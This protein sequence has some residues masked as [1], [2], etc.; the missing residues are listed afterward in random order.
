MSD[1]QPQGGENPHP[2]VELAVEMAHKLFK[3]VNDQYVSEPRANPFVI[4]LAV[5]MMLQGLLH[6]YGDPDFAEAIALD[7]LNAVPL[8]KKKDQVDGD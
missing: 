6:E 3:I 5:S 4:S 1:T 2:K 7:L 8:I